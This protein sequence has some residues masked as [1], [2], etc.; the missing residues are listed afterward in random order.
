M[1]E[2]VKL[3]CDGSLVSSR[4]INQLLVKPLWRIHLVESWY[5]WLDGRFYLEVEHRVLWYR[6]CHCFVK[7]SDKRGRLFE[8]FLG[9]L[10]RLQTTAHRL[11]HRILFLSRVHLGSLVKVRASEDH[12]DRINWFGLLTHQFELTD[13]LT[14]T[15]C[16]QLF[17]QLALCQWPDFVRKSIFELDGSVNFLMLL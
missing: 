3:M 17:N 13:V 2:V 14:V 11:V 1:I 8:K 4:R 9:Q 10:R 15:F 12:W 7:Y 16:F 6:G 5:L